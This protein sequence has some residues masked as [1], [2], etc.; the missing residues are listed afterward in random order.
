MSFLEAVL[1][2]LGAAIGAL[3]GIFL[4]RLSITLGDDRINLSFLLQILCNPNLWLGGFCY[5]MPIFLGV[6]TKEYRVN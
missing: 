5:V 2:N 3:G 1:L 6:S 4:K